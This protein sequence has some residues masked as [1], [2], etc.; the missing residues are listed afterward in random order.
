MAQNTTE[1]EIFESFTIYIKLL[2]QFCVG[3]GIKTCQNTLTYL[4]YIFNG[5]TQSKINATNEFLNHLKTEHQREWENFYVTEQEV[6]SAENTLMICY[7]FCTKGS[8]IPSA[9]KVYFF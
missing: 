7:S 8:V 9:P 5:M 6:C 4:A 1:L 3:P 2:N